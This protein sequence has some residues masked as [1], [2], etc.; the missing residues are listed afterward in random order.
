MR[1]HVLWMFFSRFL[2]LFSYLM[3]FLGERL[4]IKP[5]SL[6]WLSLSSPIS[7]ATLLI[8]RKQC[9]EWAGVSIS[10]GDRSEGGTYALQLEHSRKQPTPIIP[11]SLDKGACWTH[12][13]SEESWG[14]AAG[15]WA[16]EHPGPSHLVPIATVMAWMVPDNN[17]EK[18]CFNLYVISLTSSDKV[19]VGMRKR[20]GGLQLSQRS[21]H[22]SVKVPLR[23]AQ[24]TNLE[25]TR[26]AR[27]WW[28]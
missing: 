14:T 25:E 6:I 17:W 7:N 4:F 5:R 28:E 23:S 16:A 11:G 22:N 2:C 27:V 19:M 1:G 9:P 20:W 26:R 21:W 18:S 24:E 8:I 15:R 12:N 3:L 10:H 13:P